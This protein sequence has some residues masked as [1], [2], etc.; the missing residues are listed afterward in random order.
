MAATLTQLLDDF[1]DVMSTV[2]THTP[3]VEDIELLED[4]PDE[5]IVVAI[6]P[7]MLNGVPAGHTDHQLPVDVSKVREPVPMAIDVAGMSIPTMSEFDDWHNG[8][9]EE[10]LTIA[11]A[12][13]DPDSADKTAGVMGTGSATTKASEPE[14][15]M[16]FGLSIGGALKK[17]ANFEAMK[18]QAGLMTMLK[19]S[20][21]SGIKAI[22]EAFAGMTDEAPVLHDEELRNK[23]AENV[24]NERFEQVYGQKYGAGFGKP[25]SI[26][27]DYSKPQVVQVKAD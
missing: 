2:D 15:I 20:G 27:V 3:V 13:S 8:V 14:P 5:S 16:E 4:G 10:D 9:S 26:T 1:N 17:A 6:P 21:V 22:S 12:P 24:I 23:I 19:N 11:T 18:G 7:N 25:P